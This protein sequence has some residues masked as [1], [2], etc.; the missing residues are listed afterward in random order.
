M[1]NATAFSPRKT[2]IVLLIFDGFGYRTDPQ[3]NAILNAKMPVWTDLCNRYAFGTI[4]ASERMVGLP[5]GQFGNSEVGHL[6]IGAGRVV[7][8]DITRIDLAIEENR[9]PENPV[10]QTL[11][12]QHSVHILGLLSDGGVHSHINHVFALLETLLALNVAK[13]VVHPFLDG[14]DTP[15]R[16]ATPY[17]QKLDNFCQQHP[18]V[19]VGT[20]V[21]RFYAMDR[22]NRWDRVQAAYDALCGIEV[23]F[24]AASASESLQQAYAR[25]ENDEF[26]QA[27]RIDESGIIN[28]GDAVLFINF[29]ADRA[30]ELTQ[31]LTFAHFDGFVRQKQPK[32]AYFASITD[33]GA[34]FNHPVMFT[35]RSIAN[36]FGEYIS[37]LGLRQLRIAETEKYP[38]VTYFFNGGHET[39]YPLEERIL[40]PSPPVKTYDLQPAMSA[41]TVAK[42]IVE[43]VQQEQFDVIVCNFANGDMVG[44]TGMLG[45]AIEAVETLDACL[46]Q[47][48]QAVLAKGGEVL[49]TAD[50]GNCEQMFDYENQQSHT[51]HTTNP[52]PFLYVGDVAQIQS[53]GA[54][55]DIAPTLLAMLGASKPEEMSGENLIQWTSNP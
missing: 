48:V 45:A 10:V 51:Q 40:V 37:Q 54:L 6:N 3:D 33:Y 41:F 27:T 1:T 2:P 55:K 44:H 50:H 36:G 4:D 19:C 31:A 35:P 28:D 15:P 25:E 53:G 23:P 47:I 8:Q 21:G 18:Q 11:A 5:H 26:V 30:R 38:H 49:V 34:Q 9:L 7:E 24:Q 32:L 46:G 13:I 29:R 16:S 22:D 14:R 17:L 39:P 42:H 12:Q 43:A 52:V 20:V